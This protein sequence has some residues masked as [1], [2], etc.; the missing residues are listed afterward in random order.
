MR[1]YVAERRLPGMTS[2]EALATLVERAKTTTVEMTR[3]GIPV[4]Y[5]RSTVVPG[6]EKC[7]C[8]FEAASPEAVMVA[9]DRANIPY[10][11]VVEAM[12]LTAQ[13]VGRRQAVHSVAE[14]PDFRQLIQDVDVA[15]Y[16]AFMLHTELEPLWPAVYHEFPEYQLVLHDALTDVHLAHGNVVPFAWDGTYEGLPKTAV[17]LVHLALEHKRSGVRPTA[18]G[19]LQA[20]VNPAQQ[21]GGLSARMLQAMA[22]L[23]ASR[24]FPDLFAPIRPNQ[25]ER[26]PLARLESYVSWTRDDGLP[27]DPWQRVH[28]RLGATPAGVIAGWLTVTAP[29]R[30]W[31]LWTGMI[32]PASGPYVVPGAL[33]P[34]EID[35]ARDCGRYVEPHLWMHYRI[36]PA[37]DGARPAP[38]LVEAGEPVEL[39]TVVPPSPPAPLPAATP[40]AAGLAPPL[41]GQLRQV[42]GEVGL[43]L[44]LPRF[45]SL[46]IG[47]DGRNELQLTGEHVAPFHARV[48][49]IDG[50]YVLS[51]MNTAEGVYVNERRIAPRPARTVLHD[52]DVI[53]IGGTS[54]VHFVFE[55]RPATPATA[56]GR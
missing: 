44:V 17:E 45:R 48:D 39:A 5:L 51:D 56:A 7:V 53:R 47:R 2:P 9:N 34:V 30:Q 28:V 16:P 55:L 43:R 54:S 20:V 52:A 13:D 1:L 42:G 38:V 4:R 3:E 27:T 50:E 36:S 37:G 24:G 32:F 25:K 23:A 35:V 41:V 14:R 11:R 21:G 15:A 49:Y 26:Y 29:V 31:A 8:L 10:E 12:A 22:G 33:V 19:A 40:L 6:D 18:L 46:R